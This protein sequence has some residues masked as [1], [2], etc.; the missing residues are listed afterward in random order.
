VSL[1]PDAAKP[2]SSNTGDTTSTASTEPQLADVSPRNSNWSVGAIL[3]IAFARYTIL[4]LLAIFVVIVSLTN[5]HFATS[6]NINSV[7]RQSSYA[8]IAAAAMTLL[9]ISEAFDLSVGSM[10][11]VCG[12][13]TVVL[14]PEVGIVGALL[15][16]IVIG[17]FLGSINGLIITRLRIPTL[18]TTLGTLYVFLAIGFIWTKGEVKAVDSIE[19][20]ELGLG[21]V[22]GLPTPFVVMIAVYLAGIA[23]LKYTNYGRMVRAIGTNENAAY[24]AGVP[25]SRVRVATFILVGVCVGIAAFLQTAQLS[26]ATPTLGQGYELTVIAIVVLGGTSLAGG[27]GTLLGSFCAALFFSVLSNAL[28]LYGVDSYW[29]YVAIGAVL[30]TA[31]AIDA[32]RARLLRTPLS[33]DVR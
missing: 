27:R 20:L 13:A 30:I 18:V 8:G 23:L 12:I 7:L 4:W 11:G 1:R 14:V 6:E 3:R 33:G 22:A 28:N 16:A 17:A 15:G 26:S 24:Y 29:S 32:G 21:N 9:I 19:F 10:L 25:V 5:E 2:Q 31:L